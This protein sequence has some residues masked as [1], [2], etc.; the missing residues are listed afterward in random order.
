MTMKTLIIITLALFLGINPA[1]SQ[2]ASFTYS[3]ENTKVITKNTST[4]TF[5]E[6]DTFVANW[7]LQGDGNIIF[8][9]FDS[10]S[11]FFY[12]GGSFN[13]FLVINHLVKNETNPNQWILNDTLISSQLVS[14][15]S[16]T[17]PNLSG[18]VRFKGNPNPNGLI[19]LLKFQNGN[20]FTHRVKQLNIDGT[21]KFE[22][23]TPDEYKL[24]IEPFP[25]DSPQMFDMNIIPTY[26][27]NTTKLDSAITVNPQFDTS[28]INIDL[29][30]R[31]ELNGL[32]RFTGKVSNGSNLAGNTT[33]LLYDIGMSKIFRY[34]K[35]NNSN[36]EYL[37]ERID[38]GNYLLQPIINGVPYLPLNV[39]V[40]T[41]NSVIDVDLSTLT[42]SIKEQWFDNNDLFSIY[43][44]PF[45]DKIYFNQ[46]NQSKLKS[47][48]VSNLQGQLLFKSEIFDTNELDLSELNSG[49]YFVTINNTNGKSNTIKIIKN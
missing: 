40:S 4:L 28:S 49:L 15:S 17:T 41:N 47:V 21:F 46:N 25:G 34:V 19:H 7:Y 36:G 16:S 1:K 31:A 20:F 45:T 35:S 11:Y 8:E 32:L 44:N 23:L 27:G 14:V 29:K 6:R 26:Y 42:T 9:N 24:W 33:L 30:E 2:S 48:S 3:V 43:P 38:A 18:V 13:V 10:A 12:S 39:T 37:M 22:N 5:T